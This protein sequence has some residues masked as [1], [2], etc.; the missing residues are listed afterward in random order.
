MEL[1][2]TI[3]INLDYQHKKRLFKKKFNLLQV[4][5]KIYR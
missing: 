2:Q 5:I 4:G 1:G 3:K